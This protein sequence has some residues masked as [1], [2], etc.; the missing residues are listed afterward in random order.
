LSVQYSLKQEDSSPITY[1]PPHSSNPD[2]MMLN[3]SPHK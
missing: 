1:K 2:P 3:T